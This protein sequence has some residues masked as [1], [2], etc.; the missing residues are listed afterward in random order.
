[1]FGTGTRPGLTREGQAFL[2][3]LFETSAC[4]LGIPREN[5][6]VGYS[7]EQAVDLVK[8]WLHWL[9]D[10]KPTFLPKL[11]NTAKALLAQI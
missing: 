10:L 7:G 5:V 11:E 4:V 9:Y 3:V 8:G 1:M 6:L 2:K